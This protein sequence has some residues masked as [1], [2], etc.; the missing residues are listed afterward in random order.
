MSKL[1][2]LQVKSATRFDVYNNRDGSILGE[3]VRNEHGVYQYYP[4]AA[5]T[6]IGEVVDQYNQAILTEINHLN[7][8]NFIE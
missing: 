4:E 3:I 1:I 7:G 5:T 6:V 2:H 8:Q